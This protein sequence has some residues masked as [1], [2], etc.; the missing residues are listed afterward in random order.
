MGKYAIENWHVYGK[1]IPLE[2]IMCSKNGKITFYFIKKYC[3]KS[4]KKSSRNFLF[5]EKKFDFIQGKNFMVNSKS[6]RLRCSIIR[7]LKY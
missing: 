7:N 1:N 4:V 2:E 5:Y 6:K 3:S